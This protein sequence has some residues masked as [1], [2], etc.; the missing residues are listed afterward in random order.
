MFLKCCFKV[1]FNNY[2]FILDP[3][4]MLIQQGKIN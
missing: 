1:L 3:T 2:V 4:N